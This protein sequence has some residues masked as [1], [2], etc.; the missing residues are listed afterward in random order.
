MPAV[1]A[2]SLTADPYLDGVLGD[3]KWAVGSLT[4]SFPTSGS[5]YGSFY[6]QGENVT[7]F[8]AFNAAQQDAVRSVLQMYAS[9]TN[10]SFVEIAETSSQHADL[11]FAMSDKF[12]TAWAYTPSPAPEGG[13]A[14][15]NGSSGHYTAPVKGGYGFLTFLH[16]IGHALGLEHT[17]EHIAMPTE[18]DSLEYSVMSYRSYVGASNLTGYV[19]E[20]GGFAQSPMIYDIA[21][22]QHMYG[23]DF[24]TN[25]GNTTYSW[26]QASG[27]FLV[28]GIGQG[29]P[30]ANRVFQTVWDGGGIDTYD[31]SAYAAPLTLSLEPGAWVTLSALQL[32][33]LHWDGSALAAGN[34]A[35]A[36]LYNGDTRSLIENAQGG[37][38]GDS[39]T[40]N[41]AANTLV[42]N[43]GNDRLAG[44]G[45]ND[46]LDGG[47]GSDTI[48]FAAQ[49][50]AYLVTQLAD[51]SVVLTD[52]RPGAPDGKDI[53]WHAEVFHFLDATCSLAELLGPPAQT[54]AT[55]SSSAAADPG[56]APV[57]EAAQDATAS[58]ET[59]SLSLTGTSTNDILYGG[60]GRDTLSGLAGD[61]ILQGGAGGDQLDGGDGI[62]WA[63]YAAASAGVQV[64]LATGSGT[65]EAFGDTFRG[66]ESILGGSF[67]DVLRGSRGANAI[68]GGAGNDLLLGRG[69][70]DVVAGG[71]GHDKL[72]GHA[73][74]DVL[75]GGG[76]ADTFAFGSAGESRSSA[77]DLI[78]DFR[79]G[80]D[81]LDLRGIDANGG[82]AGNQSFRF[83]GSAPFSG[84]AGQL[85]FSG[86]TLSGDVNGDGF[87]DFRIKLAG[88]SALR[89]GD[90]LL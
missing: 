32:A 71:H 69:G 22:L 15:F 79:S 33:K 59:P 13:D 17:H 54:S 2:Y 68:K 4:Y 42:G 19:N 48:V 43:G 58:A 26:S 51:G 27:E 47:A 40:G 7:K 61:D 11:R 35:N 18:R 78:R 60:A 63:S 83:L 6:G 28:N 50:S 73:G 80:L 1:T 34:V 86:G 44:C 67:A 29:T 20:K 81:H 23:A 74:R 76:G 88:V 41:A 10:L 85:S 57:D 53:V 90:I 65:G 21:A 39:L 87:A 24:T 38:A 45:G 66:I 72:F 62:D 84:E 75:V 16:E 56:T 49:R 37:S 52:T 82:K 25:A 36:L 8:A 12:G 14:W 3:A 31:L 55:A 70:N 9:V 89:A 46:V 5:Y 30:V 64:D 77:P